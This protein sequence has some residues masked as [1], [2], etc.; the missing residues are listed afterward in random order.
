MI[1]VS[2]WGKTTF[3]AMINYLISALAG[4][5][6]EIGRWFFPRCGFFPRGKNIMAP[7]AELINFSAEPPRGWLGPRIGGPVGTLGAT[8]TLIKHSV[9]FVSG[10]K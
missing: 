3:R 4:F 10:P 7:R 2:P 9:F 6:P 1:L 5:S 8:E